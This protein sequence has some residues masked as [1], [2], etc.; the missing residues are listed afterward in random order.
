MKNKIKPLGDRVL[1]EALEKDREKTKSGI[2]LPDTVTKE[3]PEKGRVVAVGAGKMLESGKIVPMNVK[4]GDIVLFTKY[5]PNEIKVDD[6]E[7]LIAKEEDIMGI[8][9]E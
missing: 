1:I 3:R 7:Y 5:G 2:Y 9:T 6:K 4:V 8:I